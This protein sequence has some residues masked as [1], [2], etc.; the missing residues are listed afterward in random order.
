LLLARGDADAALP[1]LAGGLA[2]TDLEV[3]RLTLRA[4]ALTKLDKTV[5][6]AAAVEAAEALRARTTERDL[7]VEIDIR[8]GVL[9]TLGT[10]PEAAVAPLTR[11]QQRA[12]ELGDIWLEA[13]AANQLAINRIRVFR[14]D[15]AITFG[16]EAL[17]KARAAGLRRVEAAA[18]SN[19]SI[20]YARLGDIEKA[21]TYGANAVRLLEDIGDRR[22][23]QGSLALLG[24]VYML[25]GQPAQAIPYYRR[26]L[27][28]AQAVNARSYV[29][30]WRANLAEA[31][32]D[33]GD[34]DA[35]EALNRDTRAE[36]QQTRLSI[37]LTEGTIA[38][39]R[40]RWDGAVA[41]YTEVIR[42]GPVNPAQRWHAH[43]GLAD[44]QT[45][46]GKPSEAMREFENAIAVIETTRA[47]LLASEHRLTFLSQLIRFYQAYVDLL[48]DRGE[49][50]RAF[51][52]SERSRARI[53]AERFGTPATGATSTPLSQYVAA[54]RRSQTRFL[55]FWTAP[56]RS[57]L[58]VLTPG[59]LQTFLLPPAADLEPLVRAHQEAIVALR[60][61]LLS[62]SRA[63]ARL[64]A[65]LVAPAEAL[66]ARGSEVVI[67]ADGPLLDLNFETLP[68]PSGRY[69]LEHAVFS[70]A[71]AVA[72]ALGGRT[73][74][75][76]TSSLLLVGDP[77]SGA[78]GYPKLRYAQGEMDSV[79]RGLSTGDSVVLAGSH[80][81][82][83]EYAAAKPARFS[84]IHF[85]AHGIANPIS[86]LDSAIVLSPKNGS[87]LLHARDIMGQD[88]SADI[89]TMAACRCAGTKAYAGEGLVG[90]AWAFLHAGARN[91]VATLW[92]VNDRSTAQL[93]SLF[94]TRLGQGVKPA[95]AL[96]EAKLELMRANA[97]WHKPWYWGAFQH[98]A[99]R[100]PEP[101]RR[102]PRR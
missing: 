74:K 73:Q 48:I 87:F 22:S 28:V 60:D 57:V 101:A 45:Q 84:L 10:D 30:Y 26:A 13:T 5:D 94:Y 14:Y 71:P 33:A 3:R 1:L 46:L 37:K 72:V 100:S 7:P 24:N 23:L 93:M 55:S 96:H 17:A 69:W 102:P 27:E 90:L 8:R 99:G 66:L 29:T 76:K 39:G 50:A 44:A 9:L 92:D 49:Q 31:L 70:L 42:A 59:G 82:P 56:R 40:K 36:D 88:L 35:A 20:C 81:N 11:A 2:S 78:A 21:R 16:E 6:A 83:A 80:A 52:V 86:P 15:A 34:W 47:G 51:L 85:A 89:V 41:A 38:A 75:V 58:W 53:L 63:A 43:A 4:D 12:R 77:D 54:A 25:E 32:A 18:L 62:G 65:V 91:V 97:A 68:A 95:V 79:R 61:P 19:T 64:Y 67:V 98:Y